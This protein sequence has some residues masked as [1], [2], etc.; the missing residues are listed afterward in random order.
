MTNTVQTFIPC[1]RLRDKR[2]L[3]VLNLGAFTEFVGDETS[4]TLRSGQTVPIAKYEPDNWR[5]KKHE[6]YMA[7]L[8]DDFDYRTRAYSGYADFE[9]VNSFNTRTL[10]QSPPTMPN[11]ITDFNND[12]INV[13]GG[14]AP[15]VVPGD[16]ASGITGTN[17]S[18]LLTI[19]PLKITPANARIALLTKVKAT[20]HVVGT[21]N[22]G[23]LDANLTELGS[24]L[25]DGLSF[26][27]MKNSVILEG[28][29]A[30]PMLIRTRIIYRDTDGFTAIQK[31]SLYIQAP[32]RH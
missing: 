27:V 19:P 15:N 13:I 20:G 17:P 5:G 26:R 8:S 28:R 11:I 12:L 7:Y 32:V 3:G 1:V 9:H 2:V 30:V 22:R 6:F 16:G 29:P 23:T 21:I 10:F 31:V 14:K 4:V 24:P 18:R 25:P